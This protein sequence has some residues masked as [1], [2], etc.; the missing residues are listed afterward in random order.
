VSGEG[1]RA[2][3]E[4]QAAL[5]RI[6]TLVA[7]GVPPEEVFAAVLDAVGRLLP[8]ELASMCRYGPDET[9]TFLAAWGLPAQPFPVGT[10][11]SLGGENLGTI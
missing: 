9:L 7:R 6:A 2:L 4:E 1:N 11:Q 10:R 3:A 8:V 5:R